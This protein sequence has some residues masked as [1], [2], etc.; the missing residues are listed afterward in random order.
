MGNRWRRP[1]GLWAPKPI[2]K[3]LTKLWLMSCGGTRCRASC[4]FLGKGCG[5][6]ISPRCATIDRTADRA[7][8]WR[9]GDS[10]RYVGLDRT[11]QRR[12]AR[13]PRGIEA[14]RFRYLPS[15]GARDFARIFGPVVI[16]GI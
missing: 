8:K 4:N 10:G 5:K 11:P 9:L 7:A 14:H 1:D 3:P 6:A 15:R 13:S 2:P 16:P 12:K